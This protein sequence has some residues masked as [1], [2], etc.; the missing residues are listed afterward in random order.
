MPTYEYRREDGSTFEVFQKITDD[1]L[2]EC[3]DTGQPVK[4]VISGGQR[5]IFKGSGFYETDYVKNNGSGN[6]SNN[7][8]SSS[9]DTTNSDTTDSSED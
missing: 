1:P 9:T 5:P 3:P 7:G 4:R 2:E 8:S 6:E